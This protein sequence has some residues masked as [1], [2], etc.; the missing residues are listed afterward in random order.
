MTSRNIKDIILNE[1]LLPSLR[2]LYEEDYFNIFHNASERNICARLAHHMENIM[3]CCDDNILFMDYYVDVEYN[4]MGAGNPKFY[5][6]HKSNP[7]YMVSD[8]LIHGRGCLQNMLAI[9]MKKK[10]QSRKVREDKER[11]ESL[12][13]SMSDNPESQYIYETVVGAFITYSREEVMIELF[14]NINGHGAKTGEIVYVCYA[15]GDRYSSLEMIRDS[16]N[17]SAS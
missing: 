7:K 10:G 12:V 2:R 16:F 8:L 13:S 17:S 6:Y 14:E 1:I 15:E 11:L 5:Q 3:R 9:E 4:L